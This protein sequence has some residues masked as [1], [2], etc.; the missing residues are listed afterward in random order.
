MSWRGGM[1]FWHT[2]ILRFSYLLQKMLWSWQ[3]ECIPGVVFFHGTT[4]S[5][6]RAT[7]QS[8][9]TNQELK[10]HLFPWSNNTVFL[11]KDLQFVKT[12]VS[13]TK[14]SGSLQSELVGP[15]QEPFLRVC[16]PLIILKS[17]TLRIEFFV[18]LR[19][20]INNWRTLE[21]LCPLTDNCSV[22]RVFHM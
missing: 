3:T 20:S 1:I 8:T 11:S 17:W 16:F 4:Q 19:L 9:E 10:Q 5:Y 18:V 7:V 14:K 21:T 12:L 2:P 15:Y 6:E 13:A 22:W